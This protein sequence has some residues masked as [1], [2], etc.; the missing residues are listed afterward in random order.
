MNTSVNTLC[1]RSAVWFQ[2]AYF[3]SNL[4]KFVTPVIHLHPLMLSEQTIYNEEVA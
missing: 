1:E 4:E 2:N 3:S